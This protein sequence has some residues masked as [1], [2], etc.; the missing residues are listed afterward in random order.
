MSN[1]R[2]DLYAWITS[3]SLLFAS[4]LGV[5]AAV[6]AALM[7]A[8]R[9]VWLSLGISAAVY[10]LFRL[11]ATPIERLVVTMWRRRGAKL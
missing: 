9:K 5:V 2:P 3:Y 4:M 8:P 1:K 10:I 11:I 7:R 6:F